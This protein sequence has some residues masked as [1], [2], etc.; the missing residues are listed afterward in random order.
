[1]GCSPQHQ[2]FPCSQPLPKGASLCPAGFIYLAFVTEQQC[3][4]GCAQLQL[5][6]DSWQRKLEGVT[7]CLLCIGQPRAA[8]WL[9]EQP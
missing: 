2:M 4:L 7:A 5:A 6:G 9:L 3:E 1:M 8:F